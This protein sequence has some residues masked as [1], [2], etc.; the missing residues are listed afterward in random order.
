MLKHLVLYHKV[1]GEIG[2]KKDEVMKNIRVIIRM[3][4]IEENH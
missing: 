2:V 1:M 4:Y 3:K